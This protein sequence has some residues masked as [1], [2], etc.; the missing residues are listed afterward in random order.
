MSISYIREFSVM[1]VWHVVQKDNLIGCGNKR[2][3][4]ESMQ[5]LAFQFC[6]G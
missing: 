4:I 6:T 1:L 2:S 5:L 3:W